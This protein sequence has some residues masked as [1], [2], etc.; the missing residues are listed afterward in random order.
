MEVKELWATLEHAIKSYTGLSAATFFTF[1]AVAVAFYYVVSA[2]FEPAPVARKREV[3]AEPVEPLPPPVQLGEITEEELI[4]YD[5][6]DPKKPLLMAIKGQIYDVTQ[7]RMFYGPGGPYALF[8]GKDASRALAKMSFEQKDLTGDISG[9]GPFELEALQD[10]E[11]K[12]MSKYVKVGTVKK[13]VPV[14][15]GSSETANAS[16]ITDESVE[17][18]HTAESNNPTGSAKHDIEAV[19][20]DGGFEIIAEPKLE[21]PK[22]DV[23]EAEAVAEAKIEKLK[24]DDGDV[25]EKKE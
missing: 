19:D 17:V 2:Y 5:G 12:F 22:E 11:Y 16:E 23:D 20:R 15:D 6:S 1:V 3:E 21:K 14:T 7:S 9:L 13:T 10:W 24:E 18:S 8:A 25:E 4:A